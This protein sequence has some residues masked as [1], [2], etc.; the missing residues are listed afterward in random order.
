MQLDKTRFAACDRNEV[1]KL[2]KSIRPSTTL[3]KTEHPLAAHFFQDDAN[4]PR[5]LS[6][7]QLVESLA[8]NEFNQRVAEIENAS[9]QQSVASAFPVIPGMGVVLSRPTRTGD[10]THIGTGG[11]VRSGWTAPPPAVTSGAKA[12][13]ASKLEKALRALPADQT[14]VLDRVAKADTPEH[15]GLL[16]EAL[17]SICQQLLGA[18][19]EN[20]NPSEL[21][22][23]IAAA[24]KACPDLGKRL[25][26]AL[27]RTERE[28]E[29]D[30][31]S[32]VAGGATVSK[33]GTGLHISV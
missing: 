32:L 12:L 15:S 25:A 31:D 9:F 21:K 33:T 28:T 5:A 23:K 22:E 17:K 7:E 1:L 26:K 14:A 4:A 3:S 16:V 6:T 20:F 29:L 18:S 2:A 24:V 27:G 19:I 13:L 11:M 8:G 30:L 10:V